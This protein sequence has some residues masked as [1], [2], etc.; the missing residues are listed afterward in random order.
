MASDLRAW[1]AFLTP[2]EEGR[3]NGPTVSGLEWIRARVDAAHDYVKA[4]E[5]DSESNRLQV[6]HLVIRFA[7]H[8]LEHLG[9]VEGPDPALP[10][11]LEGVE[12]VLCNLTTEVQNHLVIAKHCRELMESDPASTVNLNDLPREAG[13]VND[14]QQ[15]VTE[16]LQKNPHASIRTTS[17]MTGV[18]KSKIQRMAAWRDVVGRRNVAARAQPRQPPAFHFEDTQYYRQDEQTPHDIAVLNE[19][20]E[21]FL[22]ANKFTGH[23]LDT[24]SYDLVSLRA[25]FESSREFLE[26]LGYDFTNVEG[27]QVIELAKTI[28]EQE[29]DDRNGYRCRRMR[30]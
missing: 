7:L 3:L 11:T 18:S 20:A 27:N 9:L 6:G 17:R 19:E 15:K 1:R 2:L 8:S 24:H 4:G 29:Q 25:E 30:S 16:Y 21:S 28:R 26:R 14:D 10:T 23:D 22:R 5:N 13:N 12:L